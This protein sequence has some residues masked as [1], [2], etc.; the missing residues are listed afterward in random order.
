MVRFFANLF[1]LVCWLI[2]GTVQLCHEQRTVA[3]LDYI[4]AFLNIANVIYLY[5]KKGK[6]KDDK[7][8]CSTFYKY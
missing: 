4:F 3:I 8:R 2:V 1:S 6:K 5:I 7:D